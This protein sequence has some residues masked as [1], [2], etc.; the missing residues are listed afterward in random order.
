MP[1]TNLA[2]SA[3]SMWRALESYGLDPAVLFERAG[4]DAKKLYDANAR[5]PDSHLYKLWL[6]SVEATQDP[7]F[8]LKVA[9]CWH[10]SACWG[11]APLSS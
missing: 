6:L 4:L 2:S 1:Y 7:Y 10:P 5:Y 8:G 9:S 11:P 3:L